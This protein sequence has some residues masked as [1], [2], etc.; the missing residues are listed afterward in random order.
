MMI[1]TLMIVAFIAALAYVGNA[2]KQEAEMAEK[3]Y[4]D[5]V[6]EWDASNGL[7]GWP[8]YNGREVCK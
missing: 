7:T 4:C 1:K 6:A 5:M 3:R 8:P 2:D